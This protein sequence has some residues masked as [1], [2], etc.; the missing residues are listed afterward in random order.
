MIYRVAITGPECTGKSHLA[1]QLAEYYN[2][3]CVSEYAREYIDT[4]GRNYQYDDLLVIAKGQF[5][6]EEELAIN[7]NK[8]LFCD[9]DFTVLKIWSEDKFEKCDP[10]IIQELQNHIYDLYLLMD[11]DMLWTYDPQREDPERRE[12]LFERY[13]KELEGL[14][15]KYEIISGLGDE[16]LRRAVEI[17]NCK[18]K[19]EN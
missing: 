4:L 16:R 2:T 11:I 19:V 9:T 10:W 3:I 12:Y 18:L 5:E 13:K 15:V 7:A 14:G 8:F 1:Q 6:K 17:I